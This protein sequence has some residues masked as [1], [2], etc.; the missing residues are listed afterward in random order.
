MKAS[1]ADS[2]DSSCLT[3]LAF[4]N[5]GTY[6]ESIF[7]KT[8]GPEF[9][10]IAFAAAA[11]AD[12]QAK[13]YYNDYSIEVDGPKSEAVRK[14][15]K[16]LKDSKVKIDGVGIQSHLS[17]GGGTPSLE[18]Q[19]KNMESFTAQDVDVALTELDIAMDLPSNLSNLVQQRT[20]YKDT[21]SACVQVKRCVG[22]TVWQ[23]SD[24]AS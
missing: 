16:L 17:I 24:K 19:R 7:Y 15:V 6:R 11:K 5:D 10:P 13:L 22:V 1:F 2:L 14:L 4:N 21:V 23:F 9:I 3:R 20:N 12:P 8:I 18:N